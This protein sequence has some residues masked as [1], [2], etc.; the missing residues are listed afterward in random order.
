MVHS[1]NLDKRISIRPTYSN[2]YYLKTFY[3]ISLKQ[4]S[5]QMFS[6]LNQKLEYYGIC[7]NY[8]GTSFELTYY[9]IF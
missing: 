1:T 2:E 6:K 8:F 7:K 5:T 9:L 3:S 4:F